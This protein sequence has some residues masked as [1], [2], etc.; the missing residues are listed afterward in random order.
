VA[1]D[2]LAAGDGRAALDVYRQVLDRNPTNPD[3]LFGALRAAMATGNPTS[4]EAAQRQ[5]ESV[6]RR[7]GAASQLSVAQAQLQGALHVLT[8]AAGAAQRALNSDPAL[9]EAASTAY[10]IGHHLGQ[11]PEYFSQF[12]QDHYL[13]K[14]LFENRRNGV[15]VDVGAYDG[16]SGSNTLYFEKFL[17]WTGLCI[18]P[19]PAQFAKLARVRSSKCVQTCIADR[20][21]SARF[22]RV[23]EGL[24]MMGGLVDHFEAVD[25][26]MVSERSSTSIVEIPVRRLDAVLK[27]YGISAIDYLSIDTE[28]SELA[29]LRSFDFSKLNVRALSVENNRNTPHIPEYMRGVGYRR[30]ARL[31]VDDIYVKG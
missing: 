21:G 25:L 7:E 24:T 29:I 1:Q 14:Q 12:G 9:P 26:K 4:I 31:G 19:D 6:Y 2:R 23:N 11:F 27:E 8:E 20:N 5:I 22:L 18:E 28:G 3:A 30:M 16:V 13:S 10:L 15:F 17:G